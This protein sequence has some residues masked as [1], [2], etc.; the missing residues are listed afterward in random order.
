MYTYCP[1]Y[2][3]ASIET[4]EKKSLSQ[5]SREEEKQKWLTDKG[6][7]VS[8]SKTALESNRHR[9]RPDSSRALELSKVSQTREYFIRKL[10]NNV[11]LFCSHAEVY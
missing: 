1:K 7:S 10:I 11:T 9:L 5:L 6:F 3:S 2:N 8:C 4:A